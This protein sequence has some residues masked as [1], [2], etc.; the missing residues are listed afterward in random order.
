[1]I[2]IKITVATTDEALE[3]ISKL[4]GVTTANVDAEEPKVKKATPKAKA[5]AATEN[6]FEEAAKPAKGKKAAK[7]AAPTVD[8]LKDHIIGLAGD[9]ADQPVKIKE[10][11]KSFG[12]IK[13]SDMTEAQRQ[14]AFDGAE[15]Y[16]AADSEED[17]MD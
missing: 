8:E 10:Y 2:E 14:E 3:V 1:M 6:A 5:E 15:A 11:V 13:I 9:S 17:P 4:A 7:K 12:V 16:F